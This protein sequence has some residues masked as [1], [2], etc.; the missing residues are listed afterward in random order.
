MGSETRWAKGFG[1]HPPRAT[2]SHSPTVSSTP[3]AAVTVKDD[4]IRKS[5]T[6]ISAE[7]Q[8]QPRSCSNSGIRGAKTSREGRTTREIL[9]GYRSVDA[10]SCLGQF[11]QR[12]L[13]TGH[14]RRDL[15]PLRAI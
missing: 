7:K 4:G 5:G 6:R 10:K 8:R 11:L 3:K 9:K 14:P 15:A 12:L 1:L 13:H 2:G